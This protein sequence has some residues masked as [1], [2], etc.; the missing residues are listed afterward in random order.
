MSFAL[1]VLFTKSFILAVYRLSVSSKVCEWIRF[2]SLK[3]LYMEGQFLENI[4]SR[5]PS[6][7]IFPLDYTFFLS[8][9]FV[10]LQSF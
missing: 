6:R 9:N 7:K 8:F 3:M 5:F 10:G 1:T 2:F 4:S